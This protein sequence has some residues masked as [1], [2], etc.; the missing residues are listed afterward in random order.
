MADF[1]GDGASQNYGE[2]EHGVVANGETHHVFVVDAGKNQSY[3]VIAGR[4]GLSGL[5]RH[6]V[7]GYLEC[8]QSLP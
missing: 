8:V 1:V 4:T 6:R 5:R 2:L 7:M 3:G